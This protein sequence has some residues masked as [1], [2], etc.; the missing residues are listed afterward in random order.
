LGL[1]GDV[2][3]R[4]NPIEGRCPETFSVRNGRVCYEHQFGDQPTQTTYTC[5]EPEL[6][7]REVCRDREVDCPPVCARTPATSSASQPFTLLNS[8]E[9]TET[10]WVN[11]NVDPGPYAFWLKN[12]FSGVQCTAATVPAPVVLLKAGNNYWYFLNVFTGQQLCSG[13]QQDISHVSYFRCP[14]D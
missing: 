3:W 4:G 9:A 13:A 10:T 6:G 14:P 5:Q 7:S 12:Q 2:T 1:S 8:G 11:N